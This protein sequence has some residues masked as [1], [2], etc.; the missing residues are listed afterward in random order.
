MWAAWA[1]GLVLFVLLLPGLVVAG[2]VLGVWW[3]VRRGRESR[4]DPALAIL[5][6]RYAQGGISKEEFEA[7]KR[8]LA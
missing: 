7:K 8:D 4:S 5:R 2:L 1:I 6:E 3:L